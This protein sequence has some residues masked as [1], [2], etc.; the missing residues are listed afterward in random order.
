MRVATSIDAFTADE[1]DALGDCLYGKGYLT[2]VEAE[3][4]A[5]SR[6]YYF[7]E[8]DEAGLAAFTSGYVYLSHIPLTFRLEEFLPADVTASLSR[9]PG[10]SLVLNT[11]IRLRSRV[12]ARDPAGQVELLEAI[13]DWAREQ[14]LA[15]V[16][17]SFVLGSD[18]M[19]RRS[20]A[21]A[22]FASA[23][24]EGDF[25]LPLDAADM[26]E[27][28]RGLDPGPRKQFRNDINRLRRSDVRIEL[29][30]HPSRLAAELADH[31]ESLMGKYGQSGY[32]LNEESFRRFERVPEGKLVVALAGSEILGFAIS[33]AG[34]GV[35][36]LL[37]YG[38]RG[39]AGEWARVYSN[40]VYVESVAQAIALGCRRVH[41]GKASHRTKTLRGC[42]YEEGLAYARFVDER[43]HEQLTAAFARIDPVN[44]EQ[45]DRLVRGLEPAPVEGAPA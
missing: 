23:F 18:E 44:R 9:L 38:R 7:Y 31:Y 19:L 6:P 30:T 1:L 28:L 12:F 22:G 33:I 39:D 3:Q 41:F 27:F 11:P 16:V 21:E 4:G 2:F 17:L 43:E 36:H 40:L 34:H 26:G 20:L 37:R 25:Y 8:R 13:V 42:L 15:A 32:E 10:R 5:R 24:Y 35:F 29:L 14:G 45:F